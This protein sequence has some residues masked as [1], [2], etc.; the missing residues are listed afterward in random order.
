[1]RVAVGA[2]ARL[3]PGGCRCRP[4]GAQVPGGAE[5]GGGLG[6]ALLGLA[7]FG[8]GFGERGQPDDQHDRGRVRSWVM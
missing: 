2:V 4:G 5:G 3:R 6:G 1:M 7:E 8:D